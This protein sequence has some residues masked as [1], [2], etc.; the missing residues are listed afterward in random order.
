MSER[1]RRL[2]DRPRFLTAV[3][4]IFAFVSVLLSA[5]GLYGVIAFL[6]N[7]RTREFGIRTALGA[8]R[9]DIVVLVQRQ[10]LWFALLGLAIGLAGSVSLAQLVRGLLFQVSPHDPFML[11]A[12][13]ALLFAISILAIVKP[14]WEA[15]HTDP[16]QA[17]RMD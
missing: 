15:A 4:F 12:A 2:N 3:L 7:G 8:T 17:L 11:S 6:V 10:V 1:L 9:L 5:A 13:A 14:A 16:A